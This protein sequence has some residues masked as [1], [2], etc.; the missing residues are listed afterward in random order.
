MDFRMDRRKLLLGA[1]GTGAVTATGL[2]LPAYAQNAPIRIGW[3]S[4]LE[5]PFATGGRMPGA[6]RR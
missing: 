5:G 3:L 4:T 6:A 2:K 1:L